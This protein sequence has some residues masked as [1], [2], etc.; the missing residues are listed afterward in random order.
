MHM[1]RP[2]VSTRSC[3]PLMNLPRNNEMSRRNQWAKKGAS[4]EFLKLGVTGSN[5]PSGGG[6]GQNSVLV[7]DMLA[8]Q[9]I[10]LG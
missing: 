4:S 1:L 8:S 5:P 6:G 7:V 10:L 9:R 2:C 3:I